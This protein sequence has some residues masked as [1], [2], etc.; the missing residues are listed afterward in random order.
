MG[1]DDTPQSKSKAA[2]RWIVVKCN[3]QKESTECGYYVMHWM[4]MATPPAS[5]PPSL[6]PPPADTSASPSTLKRTRKATRLRSLATRPPGAK[7]PV[8]NVDPAT[9]K[10][11]GPHKKKLRTYL[12]I[13][14]HDK[15]DVTYDTWKEAEFEIPE[16]FDNRTKKKILQ[17]VGERWRHFKSDLTRKWALAADK[18]DVEDI[19]GEMGPIL[20]DPQ[21]PLMGGC[22]EKG[23][24]LLEAKHCPH[25]LSRGVYEYLKEKLMA[26]KTKKR[27]DEAAQ[28]GS[29]ESI[30]DPPS[31]I[32]RHVKWK[33]TRTKKTRQMTSKAAKEIA[34]RMASQRSF[35]PHGRQDILTTAIGRP[36]HH[37][38]VCVVGA[39]VTIKQYFGSASQTSRSSSSIPPEDLEQ[40][41]QQ[42]RDQLEDDSKD[43]G[44]LQPDAVPGLALPP[45]PEVGPSGPRVSTKESCVAPSGNDPGTGDSNKCRLY[46]EENPSRLVA[47]GRLY[48]GST[49][50]HNI[51]L[52][53]GQVKVGVEE[54][55]DAEALVPVPTDEVTLVGQALNTFLAWPTHLEA[56]SPA[57]PP[58]SPDEEVEDPLYL[59]TLTIPQLFL[60]PL[61]V[62]WDAT[63]FGV[64][65]Q[66]FP[67]YIKHEDLSE[68]AHGDQC[69][70]IFVIQLWILHL[71]EPSVRA[72]NYDVYGF[73]EPQSIQRSRQSQ[74]ESESYIKSWIQSSKQDV[75]LGAYLNGGHWQMVVILPK[76]NLVVWF[77]SL[78]NRPDNYL[79]GI[80]NSVLKGLDDTPQPKSK[81]AA[82][83]IVVKCNIQK[84][85]T[86]CG[87][88]VMHWMSM[89]ILGSFRNNWE[90]YFNEVRPLEAERFKA[91]CI[92][93]AQYYLKRN[94]L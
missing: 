85:I 21:R 54:V 28:S 62:M 8:V 25:V 68:I 15:V 9:G 40:L 39:G 91:L 31:P 83:W 50:V 18:D 65:N 92:Q 66:N 42:I 36:E 88:Y 3:R 1:L 14:A 73:L 19:Q 81:V 63:I 12:G 13:V 27:L 30:I 4:T 47:L 94:Y 64:F 48:E 22:A 75:Y 82:R 17:I 76:E 80:I 56:V 93:W 79:K 86:E 38:H 51:P 6:P 58:E 69:L 70:N 61:Q 34:D 45:E 72:G 33:M 7:R 41:T 10:A 23:T 84:G 29:T 89:I 2:T 24:G 74:F 53:H 77:C 59:M 44:I 49:T 52:L 71:T 67:L 11:D 57:K 32:K 20:S 5:P 37:G 78:H 43:D 46:I 26:E 35:V 55:K 16:A 90:T 60:K 87:Y